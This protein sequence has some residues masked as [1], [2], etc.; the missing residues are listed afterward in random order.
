[1]CRIHKDKYKDDDADDDGRGRST[2]KDAGKN[3]RDKSRGR[4]LFSRKKSIA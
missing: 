4:A 2:R 1:M 3:A